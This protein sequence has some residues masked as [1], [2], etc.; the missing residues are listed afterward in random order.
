M[1]NKSWNPKLSTN[2]KIDNHELMKFNEYFNFQENYDINNNVSIYI[3]IN[4]SVG[5]FI[6][7]CK[8]PYTKT[9]L[10]IKKCFVI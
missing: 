8:I 1:S 6:N 7:H 10:T 9:N 3:I 4:N 5:W 2:K